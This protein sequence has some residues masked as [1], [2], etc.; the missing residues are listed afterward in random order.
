[1]RAVSVKVVDASALAALV[2]GEP[3]GDWVADQIRDCELIAPA[4]LDYEMANVCLIKSRKQ[5]A[6]RTALRRALAMPGPGVE[7]I[8]VDHMEVLTLAEHTGL[9][10]YDAAYL[11]LAQ[12][13][14]TGLVT[15]DKQLAAAMASPR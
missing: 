9:T 7:T 15:L 4:L 6:F 1:M 14:G 10:I 2:F 3:A 8:Q 13:M 11:W 5:P 12:S